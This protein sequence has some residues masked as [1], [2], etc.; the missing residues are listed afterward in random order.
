VGF[1]GEMNGD[2]T[3]DFAVGAAS[4]DLAGTDAGGVFVIFGQGL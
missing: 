1:I 2:I 4:N 3:E